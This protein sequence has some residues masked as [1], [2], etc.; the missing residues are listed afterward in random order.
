MC[1]SPLLSIQ[2]SSKKGI[3]QKIC[4]RRVDVE[5]DI[6]YIILMEQHAVVTNK[7]ELEHYLNLTENEKR[8][9]DDRGDS[10]P[11]LI[12]TYYLGLMDP[13]DPAD[14]LRRQVV[15]SVEELKYTE[16]ETRDPLA[17]ESHSVLPRLVHRY[18][19]RVAFL[20]TDTCA[21]Y[22]RHCFRRR[23]TAGG[24]S[25]VSEQELSA[26]T[27]YLSEH[28]EVK[29]LLLTG[30][31]PLTLTDSKLE[32]VLGSLRAVRSDLVIR[33]CTR[34]PATFPAR[35][36]D[37][38]ISI[39]ASYTKVA[40]Y[41]MTQFNH[42]RE[43]TEE[44]RT[45]VSRF[46]D[47]GIPVMNQTVL[48]RGVNDDVQTLETLMNN[49]VAIRVKPYYLFQGDLV[50]GTG[51]LR[52]PLEQ[53]MQLEALLRQR[54]SGLAMPVYAIDLPEGGGKVPLGS[55]YLIG[56]DCDGHWQFRTASGEKRTYPD[57]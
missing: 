29:E 13:H 21:T 25:H 6:W 42:Y 19:N 37:R 27:A 39:L 57:P 38:L 53:G 11:L 1:T 5:S 32:H 48:L 34:M 35:V 4:T 45:A 3:L 47:A 18:A 28:I 51:H 26:I 40:L 22:C 30:G 33:L 36:T 56:K 50:G 12:S 55:T 24:C 2:C 9:F 8:W 43:I 14:P 31:D 20:V 49:L 7:T 15:P 16:M 41:V 23:F 52:V 46:V 44:S 10:L 54:L 17:E